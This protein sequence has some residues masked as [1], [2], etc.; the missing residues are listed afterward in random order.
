MKVHPRNMADVEKYH[1]FLMHKAGT[2]DPYFRYEFKEFLV[3]TFLEFETDMVDHEAQKEAM[4]EP[5]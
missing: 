1:K 4:N 2:K 3:S 5:K